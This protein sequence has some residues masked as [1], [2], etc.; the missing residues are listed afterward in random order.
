MKGTPRAASLASLILGLAMAALSLSA[1]ADQVLD[2]AKH[3]LAQKQASQA[4][5][6]LLPLEE[7][8]AGEPD[9]DYLLG[10]AALDSGHGERAVFALE[11]VLAVQPDN[12]LARAEIARAYLL[13]GEKDTARHEFENVKREPIPAEARATIDRYLSAIT[14]A[15][16]TQVQG[17]IE[18]G[19]GTDSNVNSATSSSQIALPA[20]GGLIATLNSAATSKGDNF[21]TVTGGV[22]FTRKLNERW[23]LVGGVAGNA[24]INQNQDQFDTDTLDGNLGA[25]WAVD[26]DALT[27]ATQ[28]QSFEVDNSRYRD[29]RGLIGQWQHNL[30]ERRQ[31]TGYV[32]YAQLRYPGQD[33]RDANRSIVGAAWAQA[34]SG[35]TSP[36]LFLSVYGGDE[37]VLADGVPHLGHK[38][39]G[40]RIGGQ[41]KPAEGWTVFGGVNYEERRYGGPEPIFLVNRRDRQTDLRAGASYLMRAGTTLILQ[42]LNTDNQSNV[43]LYQFRRTVST[44]SVRFDF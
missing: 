14:A 25:R 26:A 28:M 5:E 40:L 37:A 29:S 33:I 13:I 36:V 31:V 12:A 3:L 20:F 44:V 23:S 17:Y 9:F 16:T 32:Q 2:R 24:K 41:F 7:Q 22:N 21:T 18:L 1:L 39:V 10:I 43:D 15:E 11:R 4:Y 6:L 34:F 42:V 38:P 30:D 8:R 35:R 27:L 19:V